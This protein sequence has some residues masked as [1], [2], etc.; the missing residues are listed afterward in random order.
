MKELD[1]T[2]AQGPDGISDWILR[3]C[4]EQLADKMQIITMC[5]INERKVPGDWEKANIVPI[6]KGG[7]REDPNNYRPVSLT[8]VVAKLCEKVVKAKWMKHLEDNK[9]LTDL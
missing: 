4:C 3:E 1:V 7:N 5:S 2:K 8:S 9:I 6:Y